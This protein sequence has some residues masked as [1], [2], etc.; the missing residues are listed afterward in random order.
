MMNPDISGDIIAVKPEAQFFTK[1]FSI[2][3]KK[4]YPN[5]SFDL[6]LKNNKE[7]EIRDF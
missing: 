6:V 7:D 3:L 4:G 1:F 2:E 5:A